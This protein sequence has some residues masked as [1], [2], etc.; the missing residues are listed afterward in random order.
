MKGDRG[1]WE[2]RIRFERLRV[3]L[4]T[5]RSSFM[6]QWR[7]NNDYILPRRG[8]FYVTDRN[9]GDRRNL[10]ILDTPATL[11]ARTLSAGMMAGITSPARPWF[12]LAHPEPEISEA[13]GPKAW[14]HKVSDRMRGVFL[15]S[16]LY[17]RLHM[18][19]DDV[20][21]FG[22]AA[23][24]V[25]ED[26]D[27]VIRCRSYPIGSYMVSTD[28]HGTVDTFIYPFSMTVKQIVQR[29]GMT[30]P[31]NPMDIDWSNISTRT[32]SLW[33]QGTRGGYPRGAGADEA[34]IDV[35]Y[36][37]L[38][39]DAYM[40]GSD[41]PRRRKYKGVFY[42]QGHRGTNS[43]GI[44]PTGSVEYDKFLGVEG[45][46]SFPILCPRWSVTGEDV[47]GTNCPGMTAIGDIKQLQKGESLS[48][49]GI[50]NMANPTMLAP[51]ALQN[52]RTAVVPGGIIYTDE[53]DGAKG[54]RPAFEIDFHVEKVEMKQ[55]Q[56]RR[57]ISRAFYE[58]L[59]LML[60]NSTRRQITA[61][62]VEERHEEKL[63]ALGPVLER[64]N[65]DLLDPLVDR[66]F[67]IM[68]KRGMVPEPPE[69]LRGEEIKVEYI[70][71]MAQAQKL[72][73]VGNI[74]RFADFAVGVSQA[75]PGILDKVD[76][77]ELADFY[78]DL[79][80][81]P[82]GIVRSTEEAAEMRRERNEAAAKQAE[83]ERMAEEAKTAK[84]LSETNT[85][86][87]SNA[88]VDIAG[89]MAEG[90]GLGG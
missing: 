83:A 2:E 39:N 80:S 63:L 37:A 48:L 66:T 38:P 32:R 23:L 72:A 13:A 74:E 59:F 77:D 81:V 52:K 31:A 73:G 42:E 67:Q 88:L 44:T 20:G 60:A 26:L 30:N 12:R 21:V 5:E 28:P 71:I 53:R 85:G 43:T 50:E 10:K 33:E 17:S 55:E 65:A 4:E 49:R 34:W 6:D 54:F 78:G 29:F 76:E 64:L 40:P 56:V 7:D 24:G 41:N 27:R 3:Q 18:L 87:N 68:V 62:E 57:R 9:K 79:T 19:Y 36:I 22:T 46:D 47:Y 8:R 51:T 11:A 84:T 89:A 61:R 35:T 69:E 14:L 16:N 58:D 25:F 15:R 82:P 90:G 70:S 75:K 45:Y 86:D 1:N